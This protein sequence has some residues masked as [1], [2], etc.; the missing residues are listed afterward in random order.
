MCALLNFAFTTPPQL[1]ILVVGSFS[2]L[3]FGLKARGGSKEAAPA[4][5]KH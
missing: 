4:A 2:A 1:V 3:Y 5:A